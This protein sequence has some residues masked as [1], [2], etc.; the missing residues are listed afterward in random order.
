M[1]ININSNLP[2]A[3]ILA[4][5][6]IFTMPF[7]RAQQQDIRPLRIAILN[8]MPTKSQT[9]TQLMRLLANSPLQSEIV[10]LHPATHISKNTPI[11]H[12][13]AF[14]QTFEDVRDQ[15]FDGLIITGAPVEQIPFEQVTY[16]DELMEIMEWSRKNVYSTIHICW[17]AQAGLYYHYGVDKYPLEHKLSGIYLHKRTDDNSPLLRGFDDVFWAPHSR[18]SYVKMSDVKENSELNVL[19]EFGDDGLYLVS[20][21][22]G[23]QIFVTGHPEYEANTLKNEY[24]RDLAKGMDVSMPMNYFT[25]N[26][27]QKPPMV[28]WRAHAN[29]LFNNWLNYYVYQETPYDLAAIK[30][31]E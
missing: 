23:R 16:W 29:L 14:Y 30:N 4:K 18:H 11:E 27:P 19:C 20:A 5:E 15:K 24:I 9:E 31:E 3:R 7:E 26:D 17:A 6:G 25:D 1:P 10:L 28:R 2:A 12:L 8:I 22:H 21:K 13:N